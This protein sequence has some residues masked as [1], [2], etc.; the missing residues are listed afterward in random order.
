[1]AAIDEKISEI[2]GATLFKAKVVISNVFG[3][4]L[5]DKCL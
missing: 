1:M 3:Q 4:Y 5:A 2:I